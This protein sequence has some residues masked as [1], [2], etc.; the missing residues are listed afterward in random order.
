MHSVYLPLA[1]GSM[2]PEKVY[3]VAVLSVASYARIASFGS[4]MRKPLM[5]TTASVPALALVLWWWNGPRGCVLSDASASTVRNR[6]IAEGIG[7]HSGFATVPSAL[8]H[9]W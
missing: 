9:T 6:V 7:A 8:K 2:A 3:S 5:V 4:H 1:V